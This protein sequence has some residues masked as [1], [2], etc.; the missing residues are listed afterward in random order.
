MGIS[1]IR[2]QSESQLEPSWG[3]VKDELVYPLDWH[4]QELQELIEKEVN[5]KRFDPE[6]LYLTAKE[7]SCAIDKILPLSP[8][9]N[10]SQLLCQGLNYVNHAQEVGIK[11][12]EKN[13]GSNLIFSK[14]SASLCGANDDIVYPSNT[15]LLDYEIELGLVLKKEISNPTVVS[16]TDLKDY[17]AGFVICNDV[18]A[19]DLM[20]G[21]PGLQWFQG[22]S[23]R[24]F[25]PCG[26]I[27]YLCSPE[28]IEQVNDLELK[29]WVNG[30]L[31]QSANTKQL[32]HKPHETLSELSHYNNL[33]PGDCLLTGTPGGVALKTDIKAGL[34][35]ILNMTNDK[36]RKRKF[37][38]SQINNPRYLKVGDL[39]ETEIY[40]RDQS[41]HLGKQINRV[42]ASHEAV[43]K[44]NGS[45][46]NKAA[47]RSTSQVSAPVTDELV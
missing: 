34:S 11:S 44:Q 16:E 15:Q 40:S 26:P 35:I 8:L 20:M 29:L 30:E 36:K 22:K 10:R 13:K 28:E 4:Y 7:Q 33:Y 17:I 24:T 32:I 21:A 23:Q 6:Q 41:I 38:Q 43:Y 45:P 39:V 37:V 25:C 18:S 31:R 19:R 27:L 9:T 1:I 12:R 42:V 47:A 2:Y 3:I 5:S 46:T 14:A